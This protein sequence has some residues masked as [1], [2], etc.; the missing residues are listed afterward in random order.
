MD[1]Q[2]T[3]TDEELFTALERYFEAY[4]RIVDGYAPATYLSVEAYL[5]GQGYLQRHVGQ[6]L[7]YRITDTGRAHY[8]K[9]KALKL[10]HALAMAGQTVSDLLEEIAYNGGLA[11]VS[12]GVL[13]RIAQIGKLPTLDVRVGDRVYMYN[14]LPDLYEITD[15]APSRVVGYRV[16]DKQ[17]RPIDFTPYQVW[18]IV[19]R[20]D[21]H[22][23]N[24][25]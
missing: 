18:R 21:L 16:W 5:E 6:I 4:N 7:E 17:K 12:Q 22:P 23:D 3:F 20:E 15:V 2:P 24:D 14:I 25:R 19:Y 13:S 1:N 9:L 8:W 11:F 10:E